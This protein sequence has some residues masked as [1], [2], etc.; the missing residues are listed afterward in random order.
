MKLYEYNLLGLN[1]IPLLRFLTGVHVRPHLRPE[2]GLEGRRQ[3]SAAEEEQ[4]SVETV[5]KKQRTNVPSF[6]NI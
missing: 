6:T 3:P 1:N 5:E 4:T 2:E